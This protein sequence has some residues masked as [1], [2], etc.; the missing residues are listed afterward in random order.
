MANTVEN[1][2]AAILQQLRTEADPAV[3]ADLGRRYGI[4]TD[5]A[6]GI[7]MARMKKIAATLAPD[8]DLAMSLWATGFY[9]AR[10]IAAHTDD[11]SRVSVDQMD[12]WCAN[13]DNWAIVDTACFTLFDKAQGAWSRLEPWASSERE[14]T[15]RASFALLWA[16]ALHDKRAEDSHFSDA[17]SL[18]EANASDP[19]PLV[20]KSADDGASG[21]R[22][23]TPAASLSSGRARARAAGLRR[24]LYPPSGASDR[25][26]FD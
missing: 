22:S 13:F 11:P 9:E 20:T 17:L 10:T 8:H 5:N 24:R 12:A 1:R 26:S 7:P 4:H 25:K 14:F 18:I 3:S 16:L 21:N 23:E 15:K 2:T 19:R 6:I